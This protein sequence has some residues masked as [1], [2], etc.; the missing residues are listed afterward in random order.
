MAKAVDPKRVVVLTACS[1]DYLPSYLC[2]P[3]N[4]AWATGH[5]Y[6]FEAT[7]DCPVQMLARIHPRNH[8]TWFKVL[9]INELLADP[10]WEW[11]VW[12]DADA[13]VVTE[14]GLDALVSKGTAA[15]DLILGEDI[16]PTCRVNAG[17]MLIRNTEW[18]KRLWA[19]V[20]ACSR[21][22]TKPFHEQSALC[23]WLKLN[24]KGFGAQ[25]PWYSWEGAGE[26]GHTTER[27]LV[28]PHPAINTNIGSAAH[29][30][31]KRDHKVNTRM[32]PD[33][34]GPSFAFHA[35]G[36]S[37]KLAAI[38]EVLLAHG[39]HPALTEDQITLLKPRLSN[40]SP[41]T[42]ERLDSLA[43]QVVETSP[44]HLRFLALDRSGLGP[45]AAAGLC[46]ILRA[47][48]PLQTL[49]LSFNPLTDLLIEGI[50]SAV[51]EH[52]TLATLLLER[53]RL[54][55][56]ALVAVLALVEAHHV[57]CVVNL[58]GNGGDGDEGV[59]RAVDQVFRTRG[60]V[61][62][63]RGAGREQRN[64]PTISQRGRL[65]DGLELEVSW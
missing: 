1:I 29:Q 19:D 45:G 50:R 64:Y 59:E 2:V 51:V 56:D 58:S 46:R 9:R 57:L 7:L 37:P 8:L 21:W 28:L 36:C 20:W 47:K 60:S 42:V 40:P 15:T 49:D 55:S 18:S 65:P 13:A 52:S 26:E 27:T 30:K 5:G 22:Q 62:T 10:Q 17:V 41:I 54:S 11:V 24:E 23:R 35:I 39:L 34:A 25:Q 53:T 32:G 61:E 48:V 38:R 6:A 14:A 16:S 43:D 31:I 33:V 3:V 63:V 4:R 12:V 44:Q